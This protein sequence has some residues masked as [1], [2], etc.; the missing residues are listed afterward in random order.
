MYRNKASISGYYQAFLKSLEEMVMKSSD[1]YILNTET[2]RIVSDLIERSGH[3]LL[4]IEFD[5][6]RKETMRHQKEMRTVPAHMREESYR[7][8]G[9]KPF[10]YETIFVTIPVVPNQTIGK[11]KDLETSTHS[12]SWT[13]DNFEW[14]N[15]SV[16]VS[17][18]VKG[19]GFKY[20]DQ[21]VINEVNN[22]KKQVQDWISWANSDIHQGSLMIEKELPIFIANRKK[23]LSED[24]DRLSSLAEKMGI[25][26]E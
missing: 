1:E 5:S 14:S 9:D 20:E 7:Y 15:D 26:L 13:P 10:E 25:P 11:I 4:P 19:Y 6:S 17:V 18:D 16:V 24:G 3:N 21:Q 8:E 22:L 23:K 12:W 2:S